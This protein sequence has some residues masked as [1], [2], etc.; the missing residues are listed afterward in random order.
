MGEQRMYG[1]SMSGPN[2]RAWGSDG[3]V[4]VLSGRFGVI[5]KQ[6]WFGLSNF[7][8]S[9][10][11][12][13]HQTSFNFLQFYYVPNPI[14]DNS[15][16]FIHSIVTVFKK[17][18]LHRRNTTQIARDFASEGL[19]FPRHLGGYHF[20]RDY[21]SNLQSLLQLL[22]IFMYFQTRIHCQWTDML[23]YSTYMYNS[24]HK[25]ESFKKITLIQGSEKNKKKKT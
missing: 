18:A 23:C 14:T 25:F 19:N 24:L 15:S 1:E 9:L 22:F 7:S 12:A 3:W 13:H 5:Q 21:L 17:F 2:G 6:K 4:L 20:R 11:N 8:F 10:V 16:Y